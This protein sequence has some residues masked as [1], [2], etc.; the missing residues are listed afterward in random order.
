MTTGRAIGGMVLTL[1]AAGCAHAPPAV[2]LYP[3]PAPEALLAG[4]E[5]QQRAVTEMSARVRATS[6]L[7]GDRVRATVNMLVERDGHLRFEAE[8]TLEGTVAALVT[9]GA[10]F[11]LLDTRKNQLSRGPACP[12]NVASLIR[13]PL[14]PAEVAAILLGDA[15][16]PGA[17]GPPSVDWDPKLGAD[18]LSFGDRAGGSTR[19]FFRGADD[20][21]VLIAVAR[22][23]AGGARL[24]RT[25]YEDFTT[26]GGRRLPGTIRF[27][28]RDASFDD[29]VEIHFKDRALGTAPPAGAFTLA[30]P[31][32]VPVHEVGCPS[33]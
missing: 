6:W 9:D 13:I 26:E 14:A 32:G 22:I 2:R 5:A 31:P 17:D 15:R 30:A 18:V 21:R 27:A 7:G 4:L 11:S 24:W 23:G 8:V 28:E 1:L 33:P 29:G 16:L 19:F 10:T 12:A 20:A 25:A 3:P